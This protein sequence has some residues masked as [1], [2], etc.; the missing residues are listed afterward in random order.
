MNTITLKDEDGGE[1]H[2]TKNEDGL[3]RVRSIMLDKVEYSDIATPVEALL[4]H[5]LLELSW[6]PVTE[7]MPTREDANDFAD[8]EWS[9][10]TDVWEAHYA[11]PREAT[12]WRRIVLP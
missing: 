10:G 12:H 11:E 5:R 6:V 4:F 7:R 9:D 3:V 8:V 1:Y 2:F